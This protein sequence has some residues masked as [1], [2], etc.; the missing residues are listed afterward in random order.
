MNC[1]STLLH[2]SNIVVR[3]ETV[4]RAPRHE[5]VLGEWRYSYTHSF[6]SALD[7]GSSQLHAALAIDVDTVSVYVISWR[8]VV[9]IHEVVLP[10]VLLCAMG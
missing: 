9:R 2:N 6:T 1:N 8:T 3:L 4:H 7:G 5:G 10:C